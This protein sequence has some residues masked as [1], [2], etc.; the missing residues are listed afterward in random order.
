MPER[1]RSSSLAHSQAADGVQGSS[2]RYPITSIETAARSR[3]G[4]RAEGSSATV[5]SDVQREQH[6]GTDVL[7]AAQ[8][9]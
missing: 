9:S 2:D 5:A 8:S 3:R 4:S 1:R 7:E 6:V